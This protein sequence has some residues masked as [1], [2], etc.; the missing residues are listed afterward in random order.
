[1]AEISGWIKGGMVSGGDEERRVRG[2]LREELSLAEK[3]NDVRI[4]TWKKTMNV[5]KLSVMSGKRNTEM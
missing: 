2:E 1:M 3:R 4:M 5:S